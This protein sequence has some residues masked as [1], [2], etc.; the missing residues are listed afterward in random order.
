ME[1]DILVKQKK[2]STQVKKHLRVTK[3]KLNQTN[4]S[5]VSEHSN[6]YGHT[7]NIWARI[8]VT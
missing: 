1:N 8:W 5:A 3:T 6:T 7:Y 4:K 2:I